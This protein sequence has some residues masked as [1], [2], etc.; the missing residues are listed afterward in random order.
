LGRVGLHHVLA[1]SVLRRSSV[2][3]RHRL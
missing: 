3:G 2:L 1:G